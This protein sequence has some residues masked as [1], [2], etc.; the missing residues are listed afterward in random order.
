MKQLN[1]KGTDG[2]LLAARILIA[3][4]FLIFGTQKLFG[5][6]G[7]VQYM[8]SVGLPMPALA[9]LIAITMEFFVSIAIIFGAAVRPLSVLLA[10]Y[11]LAT[12]FIGHHYWTMTGM[13]HFE[14]EIN[15]YKNISIIGG[16][17]ALY[18]T[19][20]GQY[21]IENLWQKQSVSKRTLVT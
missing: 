17:L 14:N 19:G 21:S 7:T 18:V 8:T 6:T 2:I 11:T 12:A 13:A 4:L 10:I 5:Y 9:T 16:L 15:F 3:L 20:A 1:V